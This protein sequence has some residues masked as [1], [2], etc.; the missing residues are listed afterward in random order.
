M[1][2]GNAS[3]CFQ[4]CRKNKCRLKIGNNEYLCAAC[5]QPCGRPQ[6]FI[7]QKFLIDQYKQ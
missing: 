7:E 1:P 4:V 3:Y 2:Y 5:H 6:V